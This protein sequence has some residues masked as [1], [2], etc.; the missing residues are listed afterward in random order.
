MIAAPAFSLSPE[1]RVPCHGTQGA[2]RVASAAPIVITPN[3]DTGAG[4]RRHD[5]NATGFSF[6]WGI[7]LSSPPKMAVKKKQVIVPRQIGLTARG[8]G[9]G[10]VAVHPLR[11]SSRVEVCDI[12][13]KS[14]HERSL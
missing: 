12:S 3:Q 1:S 4:T 13:N 2:S 5:A 6:G 14:N 8:D 7:P 11:A 9:S 10:S